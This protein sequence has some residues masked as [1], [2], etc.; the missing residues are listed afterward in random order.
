MPIPH[1]VPSLARSSVH[2]AV[3]EGCTAAVA[4]CISRHRPGRDCPAYGWRSPY[5]VSWLK[6]A[7]KA[8]KTGVITVST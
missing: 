3:T 7:Y 1:H 5:G 4:S 8:F 6:A 2:T